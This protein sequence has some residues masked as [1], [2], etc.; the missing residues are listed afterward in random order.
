M[1]APKFNTHCFPML[2]S[3]FSICSECAKRH[4]G[5]VWQLRWNQQELSF[6]GEEK[7][8]ALFSVGAD[9][10]ICKWFVINGGLDCT[11]LMKLKRINNTQRMAEQNKQEKTAECVLSALTPGL[12]FDFHPTDSS[13]YLTGTFEGNI[14]KCSC[15]NSHQFLETYKKH[16]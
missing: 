11:E 13:I 3:S 2:L 12:C 6:T 7:V 15:S 4:L 14:H 10:R 16:F 9:G 5:P 1:C 8:E